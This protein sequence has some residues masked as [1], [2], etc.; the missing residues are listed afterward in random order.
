MAT[1]FSTYMYEY[2]YV[3]DYHAFFPL[4][5]VCDMFVMA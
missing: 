2:M 1:I 5:T 4:A 3:Y